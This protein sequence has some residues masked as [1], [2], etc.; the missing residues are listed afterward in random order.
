M[1]SH[2]GGVSPKVFP[3]Y[4]CFLAQPTSGVF[5]AFQRSLSRFSLHRVFRR[6][7]LG[8]VASTLE[9]A[10]FLGFFRKPMTGKQHRT[11]LSP[12]RTKRDLANCASLSFPLSSVPTTSFHDRNHQR[13]LTRAMPERQAGI[14]ATQLQQGNF[15]SFLP[16]FSSFFLFFLPR[17][18]LSLSLSPSLY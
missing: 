5:P 2:H 18:S 16:P 17:V 10:T 13:G 4:L 1:H 14:K 11:P 7:D 3:L 8:Q 6:P 12:K 9:R 15:F